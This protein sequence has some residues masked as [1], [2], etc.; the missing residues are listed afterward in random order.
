MQTAARVRDMYFELLSRLYPWTIPVCTE[1]TTLL[2]GTDALT[3][4]IYLEACSA[5]L[6]FFPWERNSSEI[7]LLVNG[8]G[9]YERFS[10]W[11]HDTFLEGTWV[12]L[13]KK[14]PAG[15]HHATTEILE[16]KFG[17][18]HSFLEPYAHRGVEEPAQVPQHSGL[19]DRREKVWRRDIL[20]RWTLSFHLRDFCIERDPNMTYP[21]G[22]L[23]HTQQHY[24]AC[25]HPHSLYATSVFARLSSIQDAMD[26]IEREARA[27]E[28][29]RNHDRVVRPTPGELE[30]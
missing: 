18:R 30:E 15:S 21:E 11:A 3:P 20:G 25:H 27:C 26:A 7:M 29:L 4:G 8:F 14:L 12:A 9:E 2:H 6:T 22:I 28:V 1:I 10:A 24:L 5:Q 23:P 19:C 17:A 13:Q 16:E